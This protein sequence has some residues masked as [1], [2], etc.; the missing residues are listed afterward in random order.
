MSKQSKPPLKLV[1][2]NE[3]AL[4]AQVSVILDSI[5]KGIKGGPVVVTLSRLARSAIQNRKFHALIGDIAKQCVV[6]GRTYHQRIWKAWL[7]DQFE[8]ELLANGER[9][10]VQSE[11]V[12]SLDK[13]RLLSIR[14]STTELSVK[15]AAQ[16]IEFLF[17]FGTQE[18]VRFSD[19][20][21]A[22][23]DDYKE[24]QAA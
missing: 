20:A 12:M 11:V 24:A 5:Y 7:V 13:K 3:K 19:R 2:D 14:P 23:Y 6:E 22:A 17:A 1:I 8:Q 16:F 9:L 18:G 4:P 21:L 15:E 10:R